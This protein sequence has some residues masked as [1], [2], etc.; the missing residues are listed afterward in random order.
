MN[1]NTQL[2][3]SIYSIQDAELDPPPVPNTNHTIQLSAQ[4][5]VTKITV[6]GAEVMVIN[7]RVVDHLEQQVRDLMTKL[8]QM[9]EKL[10][11]MQQQQQTQTGQIARLERDLGNKISYD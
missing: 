3:E 11:R 5:R 2:T 10:Q 4:G 9:Q 7:P 8:T 6:N 1:M